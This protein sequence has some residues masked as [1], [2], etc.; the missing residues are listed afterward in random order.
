MACEAALESAWGESKLCRLANNLFGQK[1]GCTTRDLKVIDIGTNEIING[2]P[3]RLS[4]TQWPIF[5][6]WV[7]CFRERMELLRTS[8]AYAPALAAKSGEE[9][10]R[11]VSRVWATDPQRAYKVL[12]IYRKHIANRAQVVTQD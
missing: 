4:H 2:C 1:S 6:D 8:S 7:S 3:V 12:S 5:P 10:V 9:F 11:A